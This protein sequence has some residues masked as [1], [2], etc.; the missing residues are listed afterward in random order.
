MPEHNECQ[1]IVI[2]PLGVACQ[3]TNPSGM[4]TSDGSATLI[5]TGGTPPYNITWENGNSS[6]GINNLSVGSYPATIVD[7]YG[8]FTVNTTCILTGPVPTTTTTTTTIPPIITYDFCMVINYTNRDEEVNLSIHFNPNGVVNDKQSWISDDEL[9]T[10]IWDNNDNRWELVDTLNGLTVINNNPSYPPLNGWL[11]LGYNGTITVSEGDCVN[12][13]NLRLTVTKN[14]PTCTSCDASITIQGGGGVPPYQYSIN[15]GTTWSSSPLFSNLCSN[16][17][18]TPQIKDSTDNIVVSQYGNV[19]FTSQQITTY[20]ISF[21]SPLVV[22]LSDT[23]Y[24]FTYPLTVTPS[25][26]FGVKIVFDLELHG[27]FSRT[28]YLNSATSS[29]IPEVL[30]NGVPSVGTNNTTEVSGPNVINSCTNNTMYTTG[31]NYT[32]QNLEFTSNSNYSIKV[33]RD[34]SLN[35]R[36][37]FPG[38][39]SALFTSNY[40]FIVNSHLIDCSC[41]NLIQT[42]YGITNPTSNY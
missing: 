20:T 32:Y 40:A 42:N 29:F 24:E 37:S 4:N 3:V 36:G 35:C 9:Y 21:L 27:D 14:N 17:P 30:N 12:V 6:F 18:Y 11:I 16:V 33:T 2:F 8:D 31:Y 39:C 34:Y 7:Y 19:V 22:K 28:P 10:I 41:C 26:P 25:L 15:G 23:S 13:D 5:V 1:P 38:C